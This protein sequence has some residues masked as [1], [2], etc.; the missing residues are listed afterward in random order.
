MN[1][2]RVPCDN[3]GRDQEDASIS[4]GIYRIASKPPEAR[5][6][7]WDTFFVTALRRNQP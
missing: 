5:G 2:S 6:E 1:I 4:K 7:A 3:E